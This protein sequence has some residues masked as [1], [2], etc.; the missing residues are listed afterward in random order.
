MSQSTLEVDFDNSLSL[1]DG[2][3][4]TL[5]RGASSGYM[6]SETRYST[7]SHASSCTSGYFSARSSTMSSSVSG[8]PGSQRTSDYMSRLDEAEDP[9]VAEDLGV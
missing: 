4:N 1:Y 8:R 3:G 2:D 6:T 5:V 7:A 9:D